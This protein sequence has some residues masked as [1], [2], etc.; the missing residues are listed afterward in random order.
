MKCESEENKFDTTS[1]LLDEKTPVVKAPTFGKRHS[2]VIML[3]LILF[4][5]F[6]MRT[7]LSVTIVAMTD[8]SASMNGDIPTYNWTDKSLVVGSF[9]WGYCL[10][11]MVAGFLADQYGGKWFLVASTS[12]T[13]VFGLFIPIAAKHFGSLGVITF[14]CLQGFAQGFIFPCL[15]GILGKWVPS[16][17]RNRLGTLVYSG[18]AAGIVTC[19]LLSGYISS[20]R[21]GWPFVFY[22]LN[23]VSLV[24]AIIYAWLGSSNPN[25]HPSISFDEKMYIVTNLNTSLVKRKLQVPWKS[26]FTSSPCFALT[27][28]NVAFSYTHWTMITETAIYLNKVMHFDLT[29][30]SVLSSLP[31]IIELVTGLIASLIADCL[32]TRNLVT[33]TFIRKT[34]NNIGLIV[35]AVSLFTLTKIGTD[36]AYLTVTLVVL[37]GAFHGPAKS[38]HVVNHM[39]LAPNFSGILMGFTNGSS[40]IASAFAPIFAYIIIKDETNVHQWNIIF[41]FSAIINV[42]ACVMNSIFT[43]GERQ[44]WNEPFSKT[45]KTITSNYT[46]ED[47]NK[48]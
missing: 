25:S 39:D 33:I 34:A 14:R 6:L 16:P 31:Y 42:I 19:M 29:S 22:L 1:N 8:P 27:I 5:C 18:P 45:K 23:G 47:E 38:G 37:V 36:S 28:S 7:S 48:I 35:A 26:I 32:L 20:S 17:E 9:L 15:H 30:N 13:A 24:I 21:Y 4:C 41:Y 3:G 46:Q 43:S 44:H 40:V 12:I 11:Q 2:Q 10:P